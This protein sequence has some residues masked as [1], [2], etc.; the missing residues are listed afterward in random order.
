MASAIFNLCHHTPAVAKRRDAPV[1]PDDVDWSQ[2]RLS[3]RTI[4]AGLALMGLAWCS[5]VAGAASA[6]EPSPEL[7]AYGK[8]LVVAGD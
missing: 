1:M 4:L 5:A 3:M 7:I 6:A 2:E 8:A